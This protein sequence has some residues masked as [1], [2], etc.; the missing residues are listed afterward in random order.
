MSYQVHCVYVIEPSTEETV[1]DAVRNENSTDKQQL[2]SAEHGSSSGVSTVGHSSKGDVF[3]FV[4]FLLFFYCNITRFEDRRLMRAIIATLSL[5]APKHWWTVT[6]YI[7]VL[8]FS[9][10]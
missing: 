9:T 8:H 6:E 4:C 7:L 10:N 1:A 3:L 5:V 2:P